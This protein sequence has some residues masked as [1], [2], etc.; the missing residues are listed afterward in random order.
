MW[1]VYFETHCVNLKCEWF[2]ND[3]CKDKKKN[4]FDP[5]IW[6]IFIWHSGIFLSH[7]QGRDVVIN[8]T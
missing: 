7:D 4:Y 5:L 2:W 6:I 1:Y 8:R 3:R